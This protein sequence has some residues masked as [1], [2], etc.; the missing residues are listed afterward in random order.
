MWNYVLLFFN[1]NFHHR[2]SQITI[3]LVLY[4][5]KIREITFWFEPQFKC[6]SRSAL[7]QTLSFNVRTVVGHLTDCCGSILGEV[8]E[9]L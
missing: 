7:R 5:N 4:V 2:A 1:G 6:E 3:V 8:C 9:T